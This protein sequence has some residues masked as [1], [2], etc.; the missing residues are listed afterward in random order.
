MKHPSCPLYHSN[1][2]ISCLA[3]TTSSSLRSG[4]LIWINI[5]NRSMSD[6]RSAN[7]G[8]PG[9]FFAT[10]ALIMRPWGADI[11]CPSVLCLA[12]SRQ[13]RQYPRFWCSR[14]WGDSHMPG[15]LLYGGSQSML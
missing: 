7:S 4:I 3:A 9:R 8:I 6:R 5:S 2:C 13:Y 15:G 11:K 1:W 14:G 10:Q 12:H